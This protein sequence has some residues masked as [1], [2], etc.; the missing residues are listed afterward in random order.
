MLR[1]QIL[2]GARINITTYFKEQQTKFL[3]GANQF[4]GGGGQKS[5]LARPEINPAIDYN[6]RER[7]KTVH[8][9]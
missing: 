1:V 4:F 6:G 2:E 3:G 5:P 8:V 7:L 9:G